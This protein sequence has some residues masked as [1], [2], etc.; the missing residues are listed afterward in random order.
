MVNIARYYLLFLHL[1]YF[2]VTFLIFSGLLNGNLL[3][4]TKSVD[5]LEVR[6][7]FPLLSP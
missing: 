6:A 7:S 2:V 5:D 4:A 3:G 1:L